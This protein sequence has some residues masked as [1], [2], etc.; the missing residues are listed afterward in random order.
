MDMAPRRGFPRAEEKEVAGLAEAH[1]SVRLRERR[2]VRPARLERATSWFVARRSIQLSYGRGLERI[3]NSETPLRRFARHCPAAAATGHTNINYSR[4][5][6]DAPLDGAIGAGGGSS[7]HARW[8]EQC[9]PG[10]HEMTAGEPR[11]HANAWTCDVGMNGMP[12]NARPVTLECPV[13]LW[14]RRKD[15]RPA[16]NACQRMAC[17]AGMNR[18][19]CTACR[20][21]SG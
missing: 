7:A 12:C 13:C 2:M 1:V 11:T 14:D 5:D 8:D 18:M 17:G 3:S 21:T 10:I 9:P 16:A 19:P 20:V 4:A 15:C 6:G